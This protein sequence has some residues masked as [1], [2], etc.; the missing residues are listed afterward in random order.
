[1]VYPGLRQLNGRAPILIPRTRPLKSLCRQNTIHAIRVKSWS[2]VMKI[3]R[4][5][6]SQDLCRLFHIFL[7]FLVLE[8]KR[9]VFINWLSR[10]AKAGNQRDEIVEPLMLYIGFQG[11]EKSVENK[12]N[13]YFLH[14]HMTSLVFNNV[15]FHKSKNRHTI[16]LL[17]RVDSIL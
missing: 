10:C 15:F 1:M 11:L 8:H 12:W 6:R 16:L 13:P 7:I 14:M 17:N 4:I 2:L 5:L 9:V 3:S